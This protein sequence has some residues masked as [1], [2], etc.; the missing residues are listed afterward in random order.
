M[1]VVSPEDLE[2][3]D[4]ISEYDIVTVVLRDHPEKVT[5]RAMKVDGASVYGVTTD[6]KTVSLRAV[7]DSSLNGTP[8]TFGFDGFEFTHDKPVS[9][10]FQVN[11]D[12]DIQITKESGKIEGND[13][14]ESVS[15]ESDT[16][17]IG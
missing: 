15:V 6:R 8:I 10:V 13:V 12:T 4:N 1:T 17:T 9:N 3:Y 2:K 14:V 16:P 5:F 11:E 7:H